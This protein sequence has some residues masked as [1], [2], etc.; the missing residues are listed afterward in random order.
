MK[1]VT[2]RRVKVD[3]VACPWLITR[4]VDA[5]AEFLFVEP[6]ERPPVQAV[7]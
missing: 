6:G 4:F 3:P 7:L 1:L 5:E 2:R